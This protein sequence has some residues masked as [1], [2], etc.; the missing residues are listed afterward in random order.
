MR[1]EKFSLTIFRIEYVYIAMSMV[2]IA[3][4]MVYIAMSMGYIAIMRSMFGIV[5]YTGCILRYYRRTYVD[6]CW[7]TDGERA[8]NNN[9][10][11]Y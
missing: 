4:S 5:I 10:L 11:L 6:A 1:R 3:M 2:Y 7:Q 9:T 8:W